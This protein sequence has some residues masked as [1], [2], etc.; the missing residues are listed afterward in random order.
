[1]AAIQIS[2]CARGGFNVG[3]KFQVHH[4]H[5]TKNPRPNEPIT[6]PFVFLR[7]NAA[8]NIFSVAMHNTTTMLMFFFVLYVILLLLLLCL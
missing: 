3:G 7:K 5:H 2:M 4:T 6:Y 1:M 8:Y